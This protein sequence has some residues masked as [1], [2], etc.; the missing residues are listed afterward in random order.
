M[1]LADLNGNGLL[2][3]YIVNYKKETVRDTHS[4]AELTEEKTVHLVDGK[5]E[6]RPEFEGIFKIIETAEGPYRNEIAEPDELYLNLGNGRFEKADPAVTFFDEEGQPAGLSGD[7]GA[8]SHLQRYKRRWP[9][10]SVCC[11]RFLDTRSILDQSG[12][13]HLP[14]DRP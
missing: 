1:A 5:L 13:W 3:L 7:W 12:G 9:P 10:G 8:D 11:K 4:A 2:D 14:E 6:V